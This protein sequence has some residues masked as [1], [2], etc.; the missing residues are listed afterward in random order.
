MVLGGGALFLYGLSRNAPTAC[1]LGLAL[2]AEGV[3]N[4]SVE[5][6]AR[7]PDDAARAVESLG[8]DEPGSPGR[9]PEPAVT[10]L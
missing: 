10:G 4:A 1:M 8:S 7:L 6:I 3:V 9:A 2:A 5:D